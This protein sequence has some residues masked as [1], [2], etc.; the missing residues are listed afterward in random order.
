VQLN[1]VQ[2]R[3]GQLHFTQTVPTNT[4]PELHFLHVLQY[5]SSQTEQPSLHE[6]YAVSLND[7]ITNDMIKESLIGL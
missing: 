5:P 3:Q 7:K 2:V 6:A 1:I 4:Y